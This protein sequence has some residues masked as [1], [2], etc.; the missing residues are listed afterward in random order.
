MSSS[1]IQPTSG[2]A[3]SRQKGARPDNGGKRNSKRGKLSRIVTVLQD[4]HVIPSDDQ[5]YKY[6]DEMMNMAMI[7]DILIIK[8][9]EYAIDNHVQC[10]AIAVTW[11]CW[12]NR[13]CIEIG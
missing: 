12:C 9:C 13:K 5:S 11:V 8:F 2:T 6:K 7:T 10:M 1:S 4:Q 3:V